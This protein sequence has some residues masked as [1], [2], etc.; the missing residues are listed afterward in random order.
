MQ[1]GKKIQSNKEENNKKTLYFV[2]I[3]QTK[4]NSNSYSSDQGQR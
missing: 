2:D 3:Q 1:S 4:E